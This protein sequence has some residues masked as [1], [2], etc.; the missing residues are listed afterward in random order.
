MNDK[1]NLHDSENI[2]EDTSLTAGEDT[3]SGDT[4]PVENNNKGSDSQQQI[5]LA[6]AAS[7]R[8]DNNTVYRPP[9]R[10]N[11]VKKGK[12]KVLKEF[13]NFVKTSVTFIPQKSFS[14][15]NM[16]LEIPFNTAFARQIHATCNTMKYNIAAALPDKDGELWNSKQGKLHTAVSNSFR[17]YIWLGNMAEG[18]SFFAESDK[19]WSRKAD[20]PMASVVRK[21]NITFLRINFMDQPC[22]RNVP[23]TLTFGFQASPCRPRLNTGRQ[24]TE[25]F[26]AV[27]SLNMSLL[28]GGG[29]WACDGYDFWPKN[30]DYSFLKHLDMVQKGTLKKA[31]CIFCHSNIFYGFAQ[32]IAGTPFEQCPVMVDSPFYIPPPDSK[33]KTVSVLSSPF[34]ISKAFSVA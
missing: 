18:L 19:D 28:A 12:K 13:D 25:R 9:V 1:M 27:N 17:P 14:F 22:V 6:K 32:D 15:R 24:L 2:S 11:A 30:H 34:V 33:N 10:S 31:D 4:N 29:C 7:S 8:A 21:G 16:V 5:L 20:T 26:P 23:F 3:L